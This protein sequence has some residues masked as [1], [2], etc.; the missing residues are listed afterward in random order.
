VTTWSPWSDPSGSAEWTPM[1]AAEFGAELARS[2]P[3]YA[4]DRLIGFG[5]MAAVYSATD[6]NAGRAVA[7][8]MMRPS[9]L[10][11]EDFLRRFDREI[12]TLRRLQHENVVRIFDSGTTED[13]YRFLV[14]ELLE[15]KT[16]AEALR[17]PAR[18]AVS[19][20]TRVMRDVCAGV[21]HAH[22]QAIV[23]RDL[24]A[25]NI[26]IVAKDARA[27]VVDFGIA[28][29]ETAP[30]ST[31]TRMHG[32]PGTYGHIAP[33]VRQGQPATPVSDVFSLGVVFLQTLTGE[34]P[35]VGHRFP[36]DF[37]LDSRLDSVVKKALSQDPRNR[38][39]SAAEFAS[40]VTAATSGI[41]VAPPV[42]EP[43]IPPPV[44]VTVTPKAAG[45]D[46]KGAKPLAP[47]R[48]LSSPTAARQQ[49]HREFLANWQPPQR[50][51]RPASVPVSPDER[52]EVVAQWDAFPNVPPYEEI[53]RLVKR[54]TTVRKR[55]VAAA[56]GLAFGLGLLGALAADSLTWL[57]V[58]VVVIAS[59]AL[60]GSVLAIAAGLG[61][62]RLY[63]IWMQLTLECNWDW[64]PD[65]TM[66]IKEYWRRSEP[67][68]Y[69][70]HQLLWHPSQPYLFASRDYGHLTTW[71]WDHEPKDGEPWRSPSGGG[72]GNAQPLFSA[73]TIEGV[74]WSEDGFMLQGEAF[75][76]WHMGAM[77]DRL[78][79]L[80]RIGEIR[81]IIGLGKH[82][83]AF[84]Q[85]AYDDGP[86]SNPWRPHHMDRLLVFPSVNVAAILDVND[87][88]GDKFW[89][90]R[91][92]GF[93]S[94]TQTR[95]NIDSLRLSEGD[96][97]QTFAWHPSGAYLALE[98]S[99]R[100]YLI[101]W[102]S[103]ELVWLHVPPVG[104]SYGAWSWSEDG[105]RLALDLDAA[106]VLDVTTGAVRPAGESERWM[107][108]PAGSLKN[109]LTSCDG[110]RTFDWG[111]SVSPRFPVHIPGGFRDVAWCPQDPNTFATVGGADCPRDI[112]IWRLAGAP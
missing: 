96:R 98:V 28:R 15:G 94:F 26:I 52:W 13:G 62:A 60:G 23:H 44:S 74:V 55:S 27:V 25:T 8:K 67:G 71:Y 112:R 48:H 53:G 89:P 92:E 99:G 14:T 91:S 83:G 87:L 102:D 97:V 1:S 81:T 11:N 37:G 21:Q 93:E 35:E 30:P 79:V 76:W 10:A 100:I 61:S 51:E 5:G 109:K 42:I 49:L 36:S 43:Q 65:D 57:E 4:V 32:A 104:E 64:R 34:I 80:N 17:E 66:S 3:Q 86:R 19:Q 69:A 58:P 29:L 6:H 46:D 108:R 111:Q 110:L 105:R 59:T 40:A 47:L 101:H 38:Y 75:W 9:E 31:M 73:G 85:V 82:S 24:K 78:V 68:W 50:R 103:A 22:Q 33:E 95:V 72:G 90:Q 77:T 84:G 20:V 63:D 18:L 56:F 45:K 106:K 16:L 39:Q 2:H 12:E 70:P 107:V 54:R 7:V 88:P 41:P